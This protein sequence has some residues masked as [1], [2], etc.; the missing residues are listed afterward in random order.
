MKE[1]IRNKSAKLQLIVG[2]LLILSGICYRLYSNELSA[3][4]PYVKFS[5]D[6]EDNSIK[7]LEYKLYITNSRNKPINFHIIF[8]RPDLDWYPYINSIPEEYYTE[9]L[10]IDAKTTEY[11]EIHTT[12]KSIDDRITGGILSDLQVE[13][14][15]EGEY[16]K[17]MEKI[18]R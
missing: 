4:N 10:L 3:F 1:R 9:R 8:K 16:E 18:I 15:S 5:S 14:V 12:Y 6:K 7:N 17:R 2:I 13:I 11:Y